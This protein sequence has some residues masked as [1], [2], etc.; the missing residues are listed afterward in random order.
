MCGAH[1][2]MNTSHTSHTQTHNV[3]QIIHFLRLLH[4]LLQSRPQIGMFE[5]KNNAR[6][7]VSIAQTHMH[8]RTLTQV[9]LQA[10]TVNTVVAD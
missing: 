10:Q 4:V 5:N 6:G 2:L 1:T 3:L 7:C 8:T 9:I